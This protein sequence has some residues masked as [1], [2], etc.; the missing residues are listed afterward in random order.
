[1]GIITRIED[2]LGNIV[3]NPFREKNCL[4]L[5]GIEVSLKRVIEKNRMNILGK[6]VL[7]NFIEIHINK[8]EYEENELFFEEFR[9]WLNRSIAEWINE[10]GYEMAK[11]MEIH[12]IK[13]RL[14]R[15]PFDI[16]VSFKKMEK[17]RIIGEPVKEREGESIL[18]WLICE[19][20]G[21]RFGVNQEAVIIGRGGGCTIRINDPTVSRRH[22]SL[23]YKYGKMTLED[24]GSRTGTRVNHEK[25]Q[26]KV[27]NHRDTITIGYTKITFIKADGTSWTSKYDPITNK[28]YMEGTGTE[29]NGNETKLNRTNSNL[30]GLS[31]FF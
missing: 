16:F 20:T 6:V 13:D 31:Y 9:R 1:M 14:E 18:G 22:A 23:E 17:G 15:R 10:K 11:G 21:E 5:A 8:K 28:G 12:F 3:E 29:K 27:L 24:L 2:R 19:K 26:K 25:V 30:L 7:P 4:D